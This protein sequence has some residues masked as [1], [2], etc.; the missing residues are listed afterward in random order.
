MRHVMASIWR[1]SRGMDVEELKENLFQFDFYHEKELLRVLDGGPWA[2]EN[3]SLSAEGL[4]PGSIIPL[5][6]LDIWVQIHGLPTSYATDKTIEQIVGEKWLGRKIPMAAAEESVNVK[7]PAA[8]ATEENMQVDGKTSLTVD[9]KRWR[10]DEESLF[11]GSARPNEY[12]K[13]ER[14]WVRADRTRTVQDII[15]LVF[16]KCPEFDLIE[17]LLFPHG[18]N[19]INL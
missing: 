7:R 18:P 6:R 10:K 5:D 4:I 8:M 2:F 13:L 3:N 9:H 17:W 1:P 19:S 16:A 12:L 15:D 14:Q 11:E